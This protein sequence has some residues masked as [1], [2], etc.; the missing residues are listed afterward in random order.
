[1]TSQTGTVT[2][3]DVSSTVLINH[4][5][6]H[7]VESFKERVARRAY[8]LYACGGGADGDHLQHW[9]R[10][11]SELLA[12]VPEVRETSSSCSVNVPLQGFR[13]DEVYVGVDSSRAII[14]AEKQ[15]STDEKSATSSRESLFLGAN[16]PS[17]VDPATASAQIRNGTLTLTVK[18]VLPSATS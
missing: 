12:S 15:E 18:R 9:L 13:P 11:E 14:L 17:D 1:V 10:A 5:N 8:E 4:E 7:L 3:R 6:R 16:W 2:E